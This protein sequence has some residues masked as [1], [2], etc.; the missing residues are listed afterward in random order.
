MALE[1]MKRLKAGD[2]LSGTQENSVKN[3]PPS[4]QDRPVV[5][6]HTGSSL[7]NMDLVVPSEYPLPSSHPLSPYSPLPHPA[8]PGYVVPPLPSPSIPEAATTSKLVVENWTSYYRTNPGGRYL[9]ASTWRGQLK[10]FLHYD[11]NLYEEELVKEW[12]DELKA[13]VL[14]YLGTANGKGSEPPASSKQPLRAAL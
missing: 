12:L 3:G 13:A 14:W 11:S 7:G 1:W 5:F 10:M 2:G 4:I 9:G 6:A 8:K